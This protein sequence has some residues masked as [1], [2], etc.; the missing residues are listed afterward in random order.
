MLADFRGEIAALSAAFIWAAASVVYTGVGRQL[1]PLV[2]NLVKGLIAIALLLLTLLFFGKLLPSVSL[3]P[4]LLLL[5]SGVIGIGIGDTAYFAALNSLGASRA[6]VLESLS[7]PLGALLALIFLQ[8][9]LAPLAWLGIG[10]TIA[11]VTWVVLER[12]P[13]SN[14]TLA[15]PP[16]R[17]IVAGLVAAVGQALGAVLSRAALAETDI[18]PLW[19]TLIRLLAGILMLLIGFVIQ[20]HPIQ[21]LAPLRSRRLW[22]IVI[23]AAFAS[24]YLG[25]WLQQIALKYAP[26]GIAQSL[27]ATSPLFVI[28]FAIATGEEVSIRA[29][30]GVLITLSG[31]WLL[32]I[33]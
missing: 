9:Q 32:F 18:D 11:G 19:S 10:L 6:L 12:S 24:T 21:K 1:P 27:S 28:P 23:M 4:L 15:H 2:L 33:R 3:V 13:H 25:I 30:F 29:V 22:G 8:E 31:V 16:L 20:K 17:G 26:T 14:G 5:L 7:P